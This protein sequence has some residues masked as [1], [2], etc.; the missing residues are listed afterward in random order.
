[1]HGCE[2]WDST[3]TYRGLGQN[4]NPASVWTPRRGLLAQYSEG[5]T[6]PSKSQVHLV[7]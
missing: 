1:M 4:K 6:T 2:I 7:E 3:E 5:V